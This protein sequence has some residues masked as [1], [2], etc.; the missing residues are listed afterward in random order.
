MF[1]RMER[2]RKIPDNVFTTPKAQNMFIK[3]LSDSK[4]YDP[5]MLRAK[6]L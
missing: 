3:M 5:G 4:C 2:R 1:M 6:Q